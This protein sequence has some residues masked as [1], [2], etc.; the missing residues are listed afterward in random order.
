MNEPSGP[1]K[2]SR[3]FFATILIVV[4]ILWMA[5]TGLCTAGVLISSIVENPSFEM[6]RVI[7]LIA[8]IGAICIGPG[9][10][11]WMA[12]RWLKQRRNGA[13]G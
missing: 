8:V 9:W 7:P 2:G 10:A 4:G 1:A 12:G 13:S 3:A 6:L 5:L 11:I